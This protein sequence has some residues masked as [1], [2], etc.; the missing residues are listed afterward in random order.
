MGADEPLDPNGQTSK[1]E[2][3]WVFV[4]LRQVAAADTNCPR[5]SCSPQ[6]GRQKSGPCRRANLDGRRVARGRRRALPLGKA[7]VVKPLVI[8][9]AHGQN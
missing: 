7:S 9:A 5:T 2:L 4:L 6:T 3:H 1:K 8:Q